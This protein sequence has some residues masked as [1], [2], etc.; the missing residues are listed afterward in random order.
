VLQA[1]GGRPGFAWSLLAA[2]H[3]L[4][5]RLTAGGLVT[6]P[7]EDF[8]SALLPSV[9]LALTRGV[10]WEGE[11]ADQTYAARVAQAWQG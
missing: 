7:A 2:P 11:K 4:G 10:E 8:F 6:A 5:A 9:Y 1:A 3:N